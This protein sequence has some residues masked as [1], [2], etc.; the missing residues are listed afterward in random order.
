[1][2]DITHRLANWAECDLRAEDVALAAKYEI[3]RL[4]AGGCARDQ[5]TTQYC[6]EAAEKDA[7]I[8]RITLDYLGQIGQLSDEIE[9]LR[10]EN[11]QMRFALGYPMPA[12]LER[13]ILPRNP[14]KCGVCAARAALEDRT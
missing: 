4:R 1:M 7:H 10:I 8:R 2:T 13:H 14:F 9:R 11:V 3:E 6:A 5:G 12:E